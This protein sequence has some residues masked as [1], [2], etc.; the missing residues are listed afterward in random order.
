[1]SFILFFSPLIYLLP[2][3][4]FSSDWAII[5]PIGSLLIFLLYSIKFITV[6]FVYKYRGEYVE[7]YLIIVLVASYFNF[8][9]LSSGESLNILVFLNNM[10][11]NVL[12]VSFLFENIY[13]LLILFFQTMQYVITSFTFQG[14]NE[15]IQ[16][17]VNDGTRL[18]A[19]LSILY[20]ALII[21]LFSYLTVSLFLSNFIT[22]IKLIFRKETSH[23]VLLFTD[24]APPSKVLDLI[25][26]F[27]QTNYLKLFITETSDHTKYGQEYRKQLEFED[28]SV[29]SVNLNSQNLKA[30]IETH[31]NDKGKKNLF[32]FYFKDPSDSREKHLLVEQVIKEYGYNPE[33]FLHDNHEYLKQILIKDNDDVKTHITN[34][35]KLI[36]KHK[37][38]V[39]FNMNNRF[40]FYQNKESFGEQSDTVNESKV[41]IDLDFAYADAFSFFYN[42]IETMMK[43]ILSKHIKKVVNIFIGKSSFNFYVRKFI[44]SL[45]SVKEKEVINVSFDELFFKKNKASRVD[46]SNVSEENIFFPQQQAT[47]DRLESVISDIYNKYNKDSLVNFYVD[48]E[49]S[50]FLNDNVSKKLLDKFEKLNKINTQNSI[51]CFFYKPFNHSLENKSSSVMQMFQDEKHFLS[52]MIHDNNKNKNFTALYFTNTKGTMSNLFDFCFFH[53]PSYTRIHLANFHHSLPF[54]LK[55][56]K[57]EVS[58]LRYFDQKWKLLYSILYPKAIDIHD[59]SIDKKLFD[60]EILERNY[61]EFAQQKNDIS[62]KKVLNLELNIACFS[63][64][65]IQKVL[66]N[67]NQFHNSFSIASILNNSFSKIVSVIDYFSYYYWLMESDFKIRQ[68]SYESV[69]AT[70]IDLV[71]LNYKSLN[72]EF[73][74]VNDSPRKSASILISYDEKDIDSWENVI[75]YESNRANLYWSQFKTD[76]SIRSLSMIDNPKFNISWDDFAM[77][78]GF[79]DSYFLA[80]YQSIKDAYLIFGKN[81]FNNKREVHSTETVIYQTFLIGKNI[82]LMMHFD[83]LFNNYAIE[84][85]N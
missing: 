13:K 7:D 66:F 6:F 76:I 38:F 81:I 84:K 22:K 52:L 46:F 21:V 64:R 73:F 35:N 85:N 42:N 65:F 78:Y 9:N 41:L 61:I 63:D 43:G 24:V 39:F 20:S 71:L 32:V 28:V 59:D 56:Q 10:K 80:D 19:L 18:E 15:L 17:A 70:K 37:D 3:F 4:Q 45:L 26:N 74:L 79:S 29:V 51:F 50:P 49:K 68:F 8:L 23:R 40:V 33:E 11:S 36:N 2:F 57:L 67:N 25:G 27:K 72:Y 16:K 83:L 75:I 48:F 12:D 14:S 53:Y 1:M 62:W 47:L 44:N 34:R 31:Q 60:P 69:I 82:L 5:Y 30:I 54:T 77:N 58:T 55:D